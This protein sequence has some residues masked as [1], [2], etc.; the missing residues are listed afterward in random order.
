MAF[1]ELFLFFWGVYV[2][3]MVL[4]MKATGTIPKGLINNKI[5]LERS[6]DIQG[7]IKYMYVRGLIFSIV[8]C[9][10][11]AFL[12]YAEYVEVNAILEILVQV[13][14]FAFLIYY[15]VITVKAQNKYLF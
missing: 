2:L 10:F 3:Y 7:F 1:I 6:H 15:A 12:F 8:I 11:S 4:K 5:N 14:Y 9:I 13:I